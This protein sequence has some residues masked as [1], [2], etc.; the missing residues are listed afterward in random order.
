LVFK[1][2]S[3]AEANYSFSRICGTTFTANIGIKVAVRNFTKSGLRDG[4]AKANAKYSNTDKDN[5]NHG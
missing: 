1:C 2:A 4:S 5:V 3:R